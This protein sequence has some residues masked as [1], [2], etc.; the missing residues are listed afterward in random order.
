MNPIEVLSS[1]LR[2]ASASLTGVA[3]ETDGTLASFQAQ[4]ES[5]GACWGDDELGMAIG[6]IY[7]GALG[8]VMNGLTSNLDA[9]D[10][11]IERL[12]MAADNY[13]EADLAAVTRLTQIQSGPRP[14]LPL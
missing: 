13:D 3:E 9:I 4:I 6:I 5:L 7:Q 11:Y 2:Q 1:T 14:N 8:L 12:M 10:N